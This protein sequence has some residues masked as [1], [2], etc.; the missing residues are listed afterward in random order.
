MADP[1]RRINV[2]AGQQRSTEA[3]RQG[4]A[5]A[6]E[7]PGVDSNKNPPRAV[8][9]R[10]ICWPVAPEKTSGSPWKSSRRRAGCR[11]PCPQRPRRA[12]KRAA[13]QASTCPAVMM[14][15]RVAHTVLSGPPSWTISPPKKGG[16]CQ[17]GPNMMIER[18]NRGG[19]LFSALFSKPSTPGRNWA[20]RGSTHHMAAGLGRTEGPEN[21][22]RGGPRHL[23]GRAH[24]HRLQAC[25]TSTQLLRLAGFRQYVVVAAPE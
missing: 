23:L 1:V 14:A 19:F 9:E 16:R 18:P 10:T 11:T 5:S 7:N 13:G 21:A 4:F 15:Y 22:P 17:Q 24:H 25:G 12:S 3:W 2:D 20:E 6:G 8:A